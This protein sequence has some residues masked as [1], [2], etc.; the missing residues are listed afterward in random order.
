MIVYTSRKETL[1]LD[2]KKMSSG[3]EG[4]IHLV[5]S[6]P[7]RFANICVKIYFELKR[8]PQLEKKLKY[9][10]AHPP[11]QISSSASMI[12][13]PLDVVYDSQ[14]HFLGFVMPLAFSNSEKLV[15]LTSTTLSKRLNPIWAEKFDRQAGAASMIARLKLICNIAIPIHQLHSTGKYVLRDFKPD[16]VLVTYDGKVALVD[17]DSVQ[18]AEGNDRQLLSMLYPA[19]VVGTAEY[20]PPEYYTRKVGANAN[21]PIGKSWDYFSIAVVFYKV[22]FG[23]HPYSVTPYHTKDSSSIEI[24]QNIAQNLFPFGANA[25][26]IRSYPPIQNNFKHVP[27]E[28]KTLFRNAFSD[29]VNVR[30]SPE[31]WVRTIKK[32]IQNV[33]KVSP[34]LYP[35]VTQ[36]IKE[37]KQTADND[38]FKQDKATRNGLKKSLNRSPRGLHKEEAKDLLQERR[39][40]RSL[41][42]S[43]LFVCSLL[44]AGMAYDMIRRGSSQ[45]SESSGYEVPE[46]GEA[47][48]SAE[49]DS[50]LMDSVRTD[51][52]VAPAPV[53]VEN[54]AYADSISLD[55]GC[56]FAGKV[57]DSNGIPREIYGVL[58]VCNISEV[59]GFYYYESSAK[60]VG[61][62]DS[63]IF[64]K[65]RAWAGADGEGSY[66][67]SMSA[68]FRDGTP[69]E[70]WEGMLYIGND[71]S[72]FNGR[73][74]DHNG[75]RYTVSFIGDNY[76]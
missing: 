6:R 67:I 20:M 32:I 31:E 38:L 15:V 11:M 48:D 22:I 18:I 56:G 16:N 26:K 64:F 17:M 7:A 23:L 25:S 10:V 34:S 41:V 55:Y 70:H 47:V 59:S 14:K 71:E 45:E 75:V 3:G 30:P 36:Q 39:R 53:E 54:S 76:Y 13:W 43:F 40:N 28:L 66:E 61:V 19:S 74:R 50:S 33:P 42:L 35:E 63:K 2:D 21:I 27:P 8:T 29:N 9:M 57:E 12:G 4:D 68:L 65:G 24:W 72:A 52:I 44:I 49:V 58:T 5:T 37:T 73:I 69:P 60:K 51:T 46:F 1:T 62:E